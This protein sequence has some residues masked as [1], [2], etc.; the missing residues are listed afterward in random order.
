M[1]I[2]D[3][4]RM[5]SSEL[6]NQHFDNFK[7]ET[8]EWITKIKTKFGAARIKE[9]VEN[10]K[11]LKVLVVGEAIIDEY[12]FCSGLGKSAK[13]PI[14]AFKYENREMFMGGSL[15]VANHVSGICNE[16]GVVSLVG[17]MMNTSSL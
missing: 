10:L 5:S 12:Y 4:I 7:P 6:I 2:T 8:R 3:D 17:K 1:H 16:V 15:A 11:D 9:H 14:L 13:D